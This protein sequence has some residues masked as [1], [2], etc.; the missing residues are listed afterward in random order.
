M[1]K[2]LLDFT[3]VEA[4]RTHMLLTTAQM[5]KLLGVSRVTY[6]GWVRGK[7]IRASNNTKAR[8][9]LRK[10]FKVIEVHEWPKPEVIAMPS[11]QRFNMLLELIEPSE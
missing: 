5:A 3:Q 2:S 1:P 4:L 11:S 6:S 8:A 7:P 10:L 9:A